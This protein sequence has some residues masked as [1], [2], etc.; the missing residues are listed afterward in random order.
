MP[1]VP[2]P[3]VDTLRNLSAAILVDQE[4]MGANSRSTVGTVTD[5]YSF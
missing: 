2:R 3:D 4:R 5:A 1:N